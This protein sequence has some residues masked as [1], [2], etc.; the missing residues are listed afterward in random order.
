MRNVIRKY[1][2]LEARFLN[3]LFEPYSIVF[4]WACLI[5]YVSFFMWLGFEHTIAR[6]QEMSNSIHAW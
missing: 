6:S 1:D 2:E 4:V 5:L 3:W